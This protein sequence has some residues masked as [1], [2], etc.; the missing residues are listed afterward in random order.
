MI[1]SK[2]T[3]QAVDSHDPELN[4]FLVV[5]EKDH[6]GDYVLDFRE[7]AMVLP[8]IVKSTPWVGPTLHVYNQAYRK[9]FRQE[10]HYLLHNGFAHCQLMARR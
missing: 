3:F 4:S 8:K 6:Y 7:F 1:N 10:E 9:E 5:L 2:V